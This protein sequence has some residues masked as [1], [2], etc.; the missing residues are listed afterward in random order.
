MAQSCLDFLSLLS[1]VFS[2]STGNTWFG[3][4]EMFHLSYHLY[5]PGVLVT[6]VSFLFI[7]FISGSICVF[8]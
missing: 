8:Q 7:C 4:A 3:L 2:S 1:F 5:L 6:Y